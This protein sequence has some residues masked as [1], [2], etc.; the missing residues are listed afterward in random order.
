MID[1]GGQE[2]PIRADV[3]GKTISVLP[4]QLVDVRVA[5]LDG[6]DAVLLAPRGPRSA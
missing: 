3:V 5:E 2:L 6:D 1:R 4:D